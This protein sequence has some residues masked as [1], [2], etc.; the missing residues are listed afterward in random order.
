M[1]RIEEVTDC[2]KCADP[3][4]GQPPHDPSPACER[5]PETTHCACAQC[6]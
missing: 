4:P 6:F 3:T 1:A 5:E 2:P